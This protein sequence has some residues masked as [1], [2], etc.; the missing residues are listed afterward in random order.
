MRKVRGRIGPG[1]F[2]AGL[3]L[4]T[5]LQAPA[6]DPKGSLARDAS[7]KPWAFRKLSGPAVPRVKNADWAANPIDSF[8]LAELEKQG[9]APAAP[10]S[11]EVLLRR[12][13]FDLI[14][15]PPTPEEVDAFL[16]DRFPHAYEKVVE[17]LLTSPQYGERWALYWLDLVRFAESDGFKS[18]VA[19]PTAWRF[20]DYVIR[21]LNDDRPYDRFVREQLAGDELYPDDPAAHVATGYYRHFPDED[22]ARNLEQRRQEILND[23]TD[24]TGQVFLGLTVGCARCHDHKY[25]PISQKD[26]YRLQAFFA[27]FLATDDVLVG[28][29]EEV[30]RYRQRNQ[31]W[32]AKTAALR[33]RMAS[34]QEPY[35]QKLIASTK[36]K[37]PK[38]IQV[39]YDTPAAKR[40]PLQRQLAA[41]VSRQLAVTPNAMVKAMKPDVRRQWQDLTRQ[42]AELDPLKPRTLPHAIGITDV[43]PVAPATYV[44]KRGNWQRHGEEVTPGF[45]SALEKKDIRLPQPKSGAKTTG[46]RSALALWLTRPDHP[47]T[48]RVMMN[49]LWQHH[50]SKG[51]VASPGDLGVMGEPPTH[52]KLL[53]WLA[54]E[55]V[56][57]GWSLKAM[58]RLMVT[59][60]AYRQSSRW[61][62]KAA[63]VDPDN[64][65]LW[66][67]NRRRLEGET[68]R[69]AM[70]A[71]S[72]LL[73]PRA[74]GPSVFPEF[75]AELS[76]PRGGWRVSADGRERNRRS[77]Y[78]FAKR[79]QRYPLFSL[80]D[81]PDGNE[82]CSRRNLTT[83]APQALMLLN[84]K[85][86]LDLARAFAGRLLR[87]GKADPARLVDRA[88]R[89]ALGRAADAEEILAAQQFLTRQ[90][91]LVRQRL[92]E[93]KAVAQPV[94]AP[95]GTEAAFGA[96]L[97]DLCHVLLNVN[98]F[99]YVD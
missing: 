59:S 97:V 44:L 81:S 35:R 85:L 4:F 70:L 93:H 63:G 53:D 11:P 73:N 67:M 37:F 42:M 84:G 86:T 74:S 58:H 7:D 68:L 64:Q 65:L 94:A 45:L 33:K 1:T 75:P 71:V 92:K 56:R 79:N 54:R 2:L 13:Y 12:V 9:L 3:W 78:V 99:I 30:L 57:R 43:G 25:D 16:A 87:E 31:K 27:A 20:R 34:L 29:R 19:R 15:L 76:N 38:A 48:A 51:I 80:F 55:F 49:R 40:T 62:A 10:A 17:R 14:G 24:T 6:A 88:Y 77:I 66:R 23:L 36:A 69:D 50:F 32:E 89:L 22:N 91:D 83:T 18:D 52:P 96:T 5:L 95:D 39:A 41:M 46:R 28:G 98:E 61:N 8:V 47:L 60:A 72:G 21:A 26:Y 90:A 82:T